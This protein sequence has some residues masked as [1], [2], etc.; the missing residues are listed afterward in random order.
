MEQ[1]KE[2]QTK[3]ISIKEFREFGYLQEVNRKFL[4]PLGLALEVQVDDDG[5]EKLGGVWDYR[6]DDMGM[7]FVEGLIDKEKI[8]RVQKKWE[9]KKSLR[10]L[11]NCINPL[12]NIQYPEPVKR[13]PEMGR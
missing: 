8:D 11:H 5:T 4:H 3:Y 13:T 1:H 2:E 10:R 6:E 9:S 7:M 12:D